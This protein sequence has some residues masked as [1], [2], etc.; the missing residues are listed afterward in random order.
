MKSARWHGIKDIKIDEIDNPELKPNEALVQVKWCGICGSDLHEY[1]AGPINIP[2]KNPHPITGEVA[3][4]ILGHEYSG[5]VAEIGSDVKNIKVGDR[6]CV[7]PV[8]FC[9]ECRA[10]REG[11][12]NACEKL[13]FQGLSG[14]GGGFS[15]YT[16]FRADKIHKLPDS[17][18]FE[19]GALVE[20]LAVAYH[21]LEKGHFKSGQVAIVSGAGTIGLATIK[22]LKAM[23]ASK[24][25]VIQRESIRQ[26]YARNEG[27][28]VLDPYKVDVVAEIKKMTNGEM[29]DVSF[30]TTG[31]QLCFD[32]LLTSIKSTGYLVNTSIWEENVS[33]NMNMVVFTEKNIVGTICYHGNDFPDVISLISE[34]KIVTG[35][36]VTKKIHLNDLAS[37][38]F[39]TLT[40]P[41]KKKH[42][43]IL[44]TPEVELIV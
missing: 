5:V 14:F 28:T 16:S 44:V 9:G 30:E 27:V 6:V 29:A 2:S 35:G 17:M 24:I 25:F 39:D 3:P 19:D 21:S 26:E 7:E 15:E 43:K 10:C 22:V 4:L 13:G 32:L 33:F 11:S 12:P 18:S 1:V 38:G 34:G 31:S 36:L 40:G 8:I 20:P 37:E 23:G 41:A 42:V